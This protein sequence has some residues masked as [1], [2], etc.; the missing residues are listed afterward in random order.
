VKGKKEDEGYRY[1]ADVNLSVQGQDA[2]AAWK[3]ASH[4]AKQLNCP[5]EVIFAWRM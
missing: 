5:F 4:M 3:G 1:L 2:N